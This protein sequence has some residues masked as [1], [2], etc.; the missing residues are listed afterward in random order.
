[1]VSHHSLTWGP[2]DS[3]FLGR[4]RSEVLVGHQSGRNPAE[5]IELVVSPW[6]RVW[7]EENQMQRFSDLFNIQSDL[8]Q[9]LA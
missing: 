9:D 6:G 1:M 8:W 7:A 5:R 4:E 2:A 3:S